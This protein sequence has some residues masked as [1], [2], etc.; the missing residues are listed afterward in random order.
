VLVTKTSMHD[1]EA[2]DPELKPFLSSELTP[3]YV[4]TSA[5]I[6]LLH[7]SEVLTADNLTIIDRRSETII[8]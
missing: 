8:L 6:S 5:H 7:V 3:K 4:M 1:N 2:L